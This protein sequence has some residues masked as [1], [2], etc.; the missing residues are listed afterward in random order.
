MTGAEVAQNWITSI[1]P[2]FKNIITIDKYNY[3][4]N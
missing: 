1:Q 4:I 2:H 3:F